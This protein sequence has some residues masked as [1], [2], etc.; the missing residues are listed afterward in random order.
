MS[1]NSI[2]KYKKCEIPNYIPHIIKKKPDFDKW[3]EAYENQ[4]SNLYNI[5]IEII[6]KEFPKNKIIWNNIYIYNNL[7]KM[8]YHC[9]SKHISDFL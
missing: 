1:Y 2:I 8:L 5:I 4:I 9:S 3:I 6:N 7:C